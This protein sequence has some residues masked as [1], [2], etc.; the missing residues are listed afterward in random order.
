MILLTESGLLELKQED[1]LTSFLTECGV[2]QDHLPLVMEMVLEDDEILLEF[3]G[4]ILGKT[5]GVLSTGFGKAAG[6]LSQFSAKKAKEGAVATRKSREASVA[7]GREKQAGLASKDYR[8]SMREY[9]KSLGSVGYKKPSDGSSIEN[10]PAR[11]ALDKA[12]SARQKM[13][14]AKFAA[15]P[16]KYS[17]EL[18]SSLLKPRNTA[19]QFSGAYEKSGL[20]SGVKLTPKQ[21]PEDISKELKSFPKDLTYSDYDEMESGGSSKPTSSYP[22]I[23]SKSRR[24]GNPFGQKLSSRGRIARRLYA[25]TEYE[26]IA[27]LLINES[28]QLLESSHEKPKPVERIPTEEATKRAK[29][30]RAKVKEIAT[31]LAKHIGMKNIKFPKEYNEK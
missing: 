30:K 24:V 4:G 27:N 7:K 11:A 3:I 21:S 28:V 8:S 12:E 5:A 13:W 31:G 29:A 14:K 22:G 17:K 23:L 6:K 20:K 19:S 25:H 1:T 18:Q 16:S 26:R 2:P 9:A 15:N 10:H